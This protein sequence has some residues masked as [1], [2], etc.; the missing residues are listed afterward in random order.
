M[1]SDQDRWQVLDPGIAIEWLI[2][3]LKGHICDGLATLYKITKLRECLL[4]VPTTCHVRLVKPFS[5]SSTQSAACEI[6]VS[7]ILRQYGLE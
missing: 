2:C 7:A 6:V 5:N 4:C 1:E 3:K